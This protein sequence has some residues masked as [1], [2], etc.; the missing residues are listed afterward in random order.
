M[1]GWIAERYKDWILH[2]PKAVLTVLLFTFLFFAWSAGDFKLDASADALLL[3]NDEDLRIFRNM[4]ERYESLEFLFVTFTPDTGLFTEQS[5]AQI[6]ALRDELAQLPGVDSVTS[7]IDVP[8]VKVV[9]GRLSEAVKNYRTLQAADVDRQKAK[10]EL[11]ESPVFKELIISLDGQ[12][13]A[14][15][16]LLKPTPE[17]NRLLREKNRLL[18]QRDTTG[19]SLEQG[20]VLEETLRQYELAKTAYGAQN[21]ANIV[22]VREVIDKYRAFGSLS[23]GGVPMIADDMITFIKHDLMVF[24][25]GIVLFLLL[26]LTMIFR[27]VRW[28]I[29]PLLS[30]AFVGIVMLGLLGLVGWRVTVI[31]SNFISLMLIITMSMNIHLIVRYRQLQQD[32]P[33]LGQRQLVFDTCR[34]MVWP[35]LYTALTTMI[36]FASLVVSGIKPVID[37]GWMMTI[38]LGVTFLTSFL[39]FPATLVLLDKP[40]A[41]GA[42]VKQEVP[43]TAALA[44]FTD[45]GGNKVLL[46]AILLALLSIFGITRLK[47]ENSFINYFSDSTEIYQGLKLIDEKLGGTTTLDIL[48]KFDPAGEYGNGEA[49]EEDDFDALF[50]E[51][52][53]EPA[54]AWFTADKIER[55]KAVHDY[56]ETL[57]AVGKVLSLAAVLRIAEDL[58]EGVEFDAF[59]LAVINKRMPEV[60]RQSMIAPYVSIDDNEARITARVMDS[61]E[62]LRRNEL[63]RQIDAGLRQELGLEPGEYKITGLLVLYNNMLQSLFQS[64]IMTLG[65]VML[66][67]VLMLLLLFRSF[68]LAVIGIIPNILAAA[69][70]LGLMG[71]L[72]IPL[73]LM[74]ITIAAITIGIAVDNSIHYIYRYRQEFARSHNYIETLYYCHANIGRAVFYTAITIIAG[75]S[76]LVLSNFIPTIYFGLLTALAMFIALLAALTLLPRLILIWKPF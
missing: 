55:I 28:V 74:T 53:S 48:L 26:M 21:H 14:L 51:I 63:L 42:G 73:D 44:A 30:C 5:L 59:E 62:D 20:R 76:I 71:L 45:R 25:L 4:N 67:I 32:Y 68:K 22:Q 6:K 37:F 1:T 54:H 2:K 3:E 75:F 16:V 31:S 12:T 24:G 70:I 69:T 50:G 7:L 34:L 17:F 13:T 43:L 9:G 49:E 29:L 39:L 60:L 58:N 65:V 56:L 33:Q 66:G 27:S 10:Q 41:T 64:Q 15:Q 46:I 18:V 52:E 36:G 11:L 8:L 40:V 47:V 23:L 38:G 35:C 61:L 57:P 72:N 19:L